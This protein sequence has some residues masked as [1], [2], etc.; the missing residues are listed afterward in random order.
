AGRAAPTDGVDAGDVRGRRTS[1]AAASPPPAAS[2][3]RRAAAVDLGHRAWCGR[4]GVAGCRHAARRPR[5]RQG[6]RVTSAPGRRRAVALAG[7][8]GDADLARAALD[9][10]DPT[11]RA[12]AIGA[13]ERLGFLTAVDVTT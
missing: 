8:T 10:P 4:G 6:P 9:D 3:P 12:T 13:L 7:H 11:V 1:G 2:G 5:R